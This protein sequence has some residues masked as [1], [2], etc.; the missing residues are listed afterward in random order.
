MPS[1]LYKA[2]EAPPFRAQ[3]RR[4]TRETKSARMGSRIGEAVIKVGKVRKSP[5]NRYLESP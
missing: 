5:E 2:L 1:T 4:G 3:F